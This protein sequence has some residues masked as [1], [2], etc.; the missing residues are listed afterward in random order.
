M[1]SW[2]NMSVRLFA[3]KQAVTPELYGPAV[4]GRSCINR[5]DVHMFK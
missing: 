4:L 5:D 2:L 3:G 1:I